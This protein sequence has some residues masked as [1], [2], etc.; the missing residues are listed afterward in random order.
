MTMNAFI[1]SWSLVSSVFKD[2][3][4]TVNHPLGEQVQ[5]RINYDANGNMAAQLYSAV[6]PK[7]VS[8]DFTQGSDKELRAAFVNMICYYGRYQIDE[9]D[10]RI[11]HLV[12]GCSFPNLIGSRQIRFYIFTDD[13]LTLRTVPLQIGSSVQIGELVW[14]RIGESQ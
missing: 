14:Q 7:F 9:P 12:E 1:G 11:I 3:N 2:E 5:G 8:D 6:R 10:Q 13:K 4:G